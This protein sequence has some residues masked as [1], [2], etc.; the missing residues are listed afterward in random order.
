MK[1]AEFECL[2]PLADDLSKEF[3]AW[4]ATP[5]MVAFRKALEEAAAALPEYLSLEISLELWAFNSTK[6]KAVR[7]LTTGVACF[8]GDISYCTA[9]DTTPARYVVD[10]ELC[11]LPHDYCPRCWGSW[12]NKLGQPECPECGAQ[13]GPNLKLL[14]DSDICPYCEQGQ[15]SF[16]KP[17]CNRCG[18]A[19]NPEFVSWG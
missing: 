1:V 13:L 10:G 16:V 17:V 5:A 6:E 18:F 2:D 3:D 9:G 4:I 19:V 8:P 11:Q 15:V 7:L 12:G 14:L